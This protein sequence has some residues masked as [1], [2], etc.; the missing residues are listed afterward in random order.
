MIVPCRCF[1]REVKELEMTEES[2]CIPG[3]G[4]FVGGG[5]N[6]VVHE[7]EMRLR[8]LGTLAIHDLHSVNAVR[9]ANVERAL[10]NRIRLRGAW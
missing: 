5:V 2:K 8:N 6:T 10:N 9:V 3:F 1:G 7:L 4:P